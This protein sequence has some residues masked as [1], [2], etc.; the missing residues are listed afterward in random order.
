M[1]VTEAGTQYLAI[2]SQP[3]S[4]SA[5]R[6]NFFFEQVTLRASAA[7]E[8][9]RPLLASGN[10]LLCL[11]P[12]VQPGTGIAFWVTTVVSTVLL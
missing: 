4:C 3:H 12:Y 11:M 6:G 2:L 10:M 9:L 5:L 7:A 1:A 8:M